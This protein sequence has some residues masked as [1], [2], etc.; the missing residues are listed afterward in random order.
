VSF[1]E[2]KVTSAI[3]SKIRARR[4]SAVVKSAPD[5]QTTIAFGAARLRVAQFSDFSAV[6][7]LKQRWGLMPDSFENWERL[8]RYNPAL[9][10]SQRPIGWVLEAATGKLVGYLGNISLL[11][12]YAD[13]TLTAVAGSGFVIEP[14]YRTAS[15]SL[16]AAFYQQKDVDLYLTT[17]AI[18]VVGRIA[19]V[20][21]CDPLPQPDYDTVLFWVLQTHPFSQ[22][23]MRELRLGPAISLLGA[24]VAS[25]ALGID[26]ALRRRLPRSSTGDLSVVE[27]EVSEIGDDFQTLWLEKLQEPPRLL[28]D[29]RPAALRWHFEIPGDRGT[30]SVLCCYRNRELLGYAVVRHDPFEENALRRSI[31][32]DTLVKRDD[33]AIVKALWLAAYH[34]ARRA[35]SHVLEVLGFPPSIRHACA[36]WRPYSRKYPACPFYYKA[37]AA[38]LHKTLSEAD[39]WYASPFDGDTT[40][41]QPSFSSAVVSDKTAVQTE[42]L[43]ERFASRIADRRPEVL[44]SIPQP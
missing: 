24:G 28:A 26:R 11:Y 19:R 4:E 35:G 10:H 42:N 17:T 41:V 14:G 8:W 1:I 22:N 13:R 29:R 38:N 15:L 5:V 6:A 9:I 16:N 40:L 7:E 18:E 21:K 31:I 23:V 2:R 27:I 37:P 44:D 34:R 33:P 43:N 36:Q 32:A 25:A 39:A 12:R 30:T 20:Y 3:L